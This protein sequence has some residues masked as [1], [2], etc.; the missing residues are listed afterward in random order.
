MKEKNGNRGN[1]RD[2]K[3]KRPKV[4]KWE[5]GRKER[6]GSYEAEMEKEGRTL[7]ETQVLT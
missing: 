3:M 2:T 5:R 1:K 6:N 7:T 4:R